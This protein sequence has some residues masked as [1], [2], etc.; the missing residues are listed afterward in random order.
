MLH[1]TFQTAPRY[2]REL[3]CDGPTAV[4]DAAPPYIMGVNYIRSNE[5]CIKVVN[6][7]L[8]WEMVDPPPAFTEYVYRIQPDAIDIILA[9]IDSESKYADILRLLKSRDCCKAVDMTE[10]CMLIRA[11]CDITYKTYAHFAA[12][13]D[14]TCVNIIYDYINTHGFSKHDSARGY[15]YAEYRKGFGS[16]D[17]SEGDEGASEMREYHVRACSIMAANKHAECLKF[18]MSRN[19]KYWDFEADCDDIIKDDSVDCL[20]VSAFIQ[21]K[22]LPSH[23]IFIGHAPVTDDHPD[24]LTLVEQRCLFAVKH[25]SF[26]CLKLMIQSYPTMSFENIITECIVLDQVDC[27]RV[28]FNATAS[29]SIYIM[30]AAQHGSIECLK[31]L[32]LCGPTIGNNVLKCALNAPESSKKD[33]CVKYLISANKNCADANIWRICM[34]EP[35]VIFLTNLML[36]NTEHPDINLAAI[37]VE[38]NSLNT[39]KAITWSKSFTL[40]YDLLHTMIANGQYA[41]MR[42]YIR[43]FSPDVDSIVGPIHPDCLNYVRAYKFMPMF[44]FR[45]YDSIVDCMY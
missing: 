22:Q 28:I 9:G 34:S 20:V 39:M 19:P 33:H 4:E 24:T 45:I 31:F 13:G 25:N 14:V 15:D 29:S 30:L 16:T 18:M 26:K 40:D 36:N 11:D 35:N 12:L 8:E 1:Q 43:K 7:F 32:H 21:C 23:P 3:E 2:V 17:D 37:A 41:M 5:L 10:L 38:Q 27:C 6:L 44:M 42:Y